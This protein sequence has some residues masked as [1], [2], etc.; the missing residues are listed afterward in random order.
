MTAPQSS[1]RSR[2][3]KYGRKAMNEKRKWL[4]WAVELQSLAQAGL[5]YGRDAYD[6]ERYQRVREIAAEMVA[7]QSELPVEK[8]T[9]VRLQWLAQKGQGELAD[10]V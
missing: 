8:V 6:R 3:C 1:P 10:W 9:M 2:F 7:Q 4:D 5:F